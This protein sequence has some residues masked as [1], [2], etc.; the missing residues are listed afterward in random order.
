MNID[1]LYCYE[2]L[3]TLSQKNTASH[4]VMKLRHRISSVLLCLVARRQPD[5][6]V[7]HIVPIVRLEE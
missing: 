1:T 5:V 2:T 3:V 7:E 6:S 4:R